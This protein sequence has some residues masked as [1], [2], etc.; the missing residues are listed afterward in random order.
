MKDISHYK[1]LLKAKGLPTSRIKFRGHR[2]YGN[3]YLEVT[4]NSDTA[5]ISLV[6]AILNADCRGD[7]VPV[8]TRESDPMINILSDSYI[9][10]IRRT[11]NENNNNGS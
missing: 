11:Q 6:R 3:Q 5:D 4:L 8:V 2:T 1:D 10:K 7:C 9:S